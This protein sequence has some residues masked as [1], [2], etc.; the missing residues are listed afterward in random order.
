M[1]RM[2]RVWI[3]EDVIRDIMFYSAS[4]DVAHLGMTCRC[5][6]QIYLDVVF[7]EMESL[8]PLYGVLPDPIAPAS[9]PTGLKALITRQNFGKAPKQP[10]SYSLQSLRIIADD[11]NTIASSVPLALPTLR[12]FDLTINFE[13]RKRNQAVKDSYESSGL[14]AYIRHLRSLP[15]LD[16]LTITCTNAVRR[17][18][19][20]VEAHGLLF[21]SRQFPQLKTIEL[22]NLVLNE[23]L[24][25]NLSKMPTL[26]RL[27]VCL[28]NG[29]E[30]VLTTGPLVFPGLR[31][32]IIDCEGATELS[33]FM[34]GLQAPGL[35]SIQLQVEDDAFCPQ[36]ASKF[37]ELVGAKFRHLRAFGLHPWSADGSDRTWTFQSFQGLLKCHELES[38]GVALPSRVIATDDDVRNI[39]KA[40]PELQELQLGHSQD[41]TDFPRAT[42]GGLAALA[43][44]VPALSSLRLAVLPAL[45][46][47]RAASLL[48]APISP[49]LLEEL[50]FHDLPADRPPSAFIEGMAHVIL[51]LF[52]RLQSFTCSRR[53][54]K[55]ASHNSSTVAARMEK[56]YPL[57]ARDIAICIGEAYR[58]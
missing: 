5:L 4:R 42:F 55:T 9:A 49:S 34:H 12:R 15:R 57:S 48:R 24:I 28:P 14:P 50:A 58:V 26:E 6:F 36:T 47:D 1:P 46:K 37:S 40:W 56:G 38:F 33:W 11:P 20:E 35:A 53:T 30:H 17:H 7:G 27:H 51:H 32:M 2:H 25:Y 45:T 54:S 44:G 10:K 41:T 39:A 23:A 52:P 31:H 19:S 8:R 16:S 21:L 43:W 3:V 18:V 13:D 22:T 29:K